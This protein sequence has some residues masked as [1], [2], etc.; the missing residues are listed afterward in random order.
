M[1]D[2]EERRSGREDLQDASYVRMD[3]C[4]DSLHGYSGRLGKHTGSGPLARL[5]SEDRTGNR[6]QK[7]CQAQGESMTYHDLPIGAYFK[8]VF[9]L[10]DR[11]IVDDLMF[12]K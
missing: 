4:P 12:V 2:D 3:R 8:R 6:D 9:K 1:Q 10:S 11:T 7:C 5:G